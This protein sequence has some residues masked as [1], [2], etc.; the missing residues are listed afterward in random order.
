VP[1]VHKLLIANRGE[2]AIRIARTA[3]AMGIATVTVFSD[4]DAESPHIAAA[5]EAVRLP[6][7]TAAQTYLRDDLL[8]GAAQATGADAVHPGY[9]FR[10]ESAEFARRVLDA[11]LVFVGPSPAATAA[12]GDKIA[13]KELL[14]RAGVPVLPGSTVHDH[15]DL[16][17]AAG[18][19]GFP[20]L[21]KAA[22]GGGGRGMRVV[23][24]RAG[25]HDAVA[26]A[27]REAGA[28][29]GDDTVFLEQLVERPR[30][31]E[32]QIFGDTHGTVISLFERDCSV[33]RRHQKLIEE[34]PSPAVDEALRAELAAAA[35]A[36]GK[37][38][39]YVGA[40]T[41]EFVVDRAKG[42]HVLEVN[43]R[44]QVEHPVT[45]LTTGLDLVRLQLLVAQGHRLPT[46][47]TATGHA[48][49]ARL[50]A[51][52]PLRDFAPTTGLL[53]RFRI[54]AADGIRVDP[55]VV[56]GTAVGPYYDSLL[57]KVV[58]YA[59]TREEARRKL[60]YA[61][62][63]AHLHGPR[64]NRDLLV[65]IVRE[66]EFAAGEADTGYLDRH[67]PAEL[68]GT[69]TAIP[70]HAVAAALA[71]Q[72]ERRAGAR[73]LGTIASG[74]RNVRSADQQVTYSHDAG[75]TTVTYRLADRHLT[76]DGTPLPNPVVRAAS[77]DRVD[78]ET[79]GVRRTIEIHRVG[80]T[81]Y[82]DS[83]LGASVF[84]RV[85]RLPEPA[86]PA[87][88]PTGSL[89]AETPGTVV[90]VAVAEGDRV[91][92][93]QVVLAV[94]AMKM[95]HE[96]TAPHAGFVT[97]LPVLPGEPV[98]AGAV[99]AVISPTPDPTDTPSTPPAP[100]ATQ[101]ATT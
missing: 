7:R 44:L 84:T 49:E 41:V 29:F 37:A 99:L 80:D 5:D 73:V 75:R 39:D 28:A 50:Y 21:V 76:V 51:E 90:R 64:T 12:M 56:D 62:A 40:G 17:E 72:A 24:D 74:W 27:R 63:G 35:V 2:I 42:F 85:P 19:I 9:G 32:V 94:E 61:L 4:A 57:A 92:A 18:R 71:E 22:F 47:V 86:E 69:R 81:V 13:A 53:H 59:P 8:L 68:A 97:H 93:G 31:I 87:A 66:P 79:G 95:E 3:R 25:L 89:L 23:R 100:A 36:A 6:G 20:I 34:T 45:E 78:L 16:D 96:V 91:D 15:T 65:A 70:V 82:V 43:T 88:E 54:P 11:G 26:A 30:H 98:D 38:I 33:Q 58:A 60:A 1:P 46:D 10:S 101:E 48:I 55:G 83:P 67:P 77:A 14:A 52:D